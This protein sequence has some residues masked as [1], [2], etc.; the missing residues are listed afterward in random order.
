MLQSIKYCFV[1]FLLLVVGSCKK[2][3][4]SMGDLTAPTEVTINTKIAGQDAANPNGDGSGNVEITLTGK[5]ALSYNIDYDAADG[6]SM[7][8]LEKAKT[9]RKYTKIGLNTYRITVVAYGPGGT[10]TTVTKDI[11]VQSNFTPD[12]TIVTNLTGTGSKTWKVDKDLA[13]HFGVGP[14]SATSV[15]PEWYAAAPNEKAGCCNCMYSASFTFTKT[16]TGYT[17]T[18]TTP[19]GAFT[20]TG[21]LA[22]GL[23]GI[24]AS[25]SEGCYPYSGGTSSFS[26]V[27]AGSGIATGT[28]KT[29][30][31]LGGNNTFIGYGAVQ[32]EYEIISIN[33]TTMYL[34]VQGTETGNAWYLRLKTT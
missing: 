18:T 19:E 25:G 28:T 21:A 8:F 15:T 16:A 24:P 30:I 4:Y 6:I 11:Q 31:Q 1:L 5:N 22:G 13:A 17:I 32:K 26:F 10:A 27:P 2:S 29:A 14:W 20:K 7:V 12:A 3:E 23:P 9:T 34:R 33:A